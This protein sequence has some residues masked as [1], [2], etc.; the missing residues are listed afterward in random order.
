MDIALSNAH[1][2]KDNINQIVLVGGST[3]IPKVKQIVE[4][5]F[6]GCKIND[7]INPDEAVAYGAT[8]DAEKILH[9][10][11]NNITNFHLLDITP[12]S[13]GT[14][15]LNKSQDPKIK[16]FNYLL[17]FNFFIFLYLL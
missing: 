3:R 16:D 14:N 11:D 15:V 8:I 6:P 1:L 7:K 17:N 2:T 10:K 13:L 5:Y 9:N 4:N 12:L